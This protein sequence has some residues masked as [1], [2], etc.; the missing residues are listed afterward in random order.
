MTS[1]SDRLDRIEAVLER[2]VAASNERMTRLEQ[3]MERQ[4]KENNERFKATDERLK[5]MDELQKYLEVRPDQVRGAIA[6]LA[7]LSHAGKPFF[8]DGVDLGLLG[9]PLF[10]E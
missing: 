7:M 8:D 9:C 2:S 6:S 10:R 5:A 3:T 1:S 4:N